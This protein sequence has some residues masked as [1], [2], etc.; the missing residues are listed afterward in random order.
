MSY[1]S[2]CCNKVS[3]KSNIRKGGSNLAYGPTAQNKTKRRQAA[4]DGSV[5]T[6]TASLT[7]LIVP[8]EPEPETR[9]ENPASEHCFQHPW[10]IKH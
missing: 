5:V 7:A 10:L 8:T 1:L 2:H 4:L 9:Y 3:D 6:E